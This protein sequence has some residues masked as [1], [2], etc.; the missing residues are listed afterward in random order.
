MPRPAVGPSDLSSFT[1]VKNLLCTFQVVDQTALE[2]IFRR[3]RVFHKYNILRFGVNAIAYFFA[4][5]LLL[6]ETHGNGP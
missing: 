2:R 3:Y 6:I 1:R 4:H 5:S